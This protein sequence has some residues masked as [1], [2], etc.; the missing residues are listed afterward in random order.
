MSRNARRRLL[1]GLAIALPAAWTRPIVESVIL[2]AHAQTSAPGCS[3]PAGCYVTPE[4]FGFQSFQWPGGARPFAVD[5][6]STV[7]CEGEAESFTMVVGPGPAEAAELITCGDS[8]TL[9]QVSTTPSIVPD[10]GFFTCIV[11]N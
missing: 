1:Q 10:C 11:G 9:V 5:T 2:P 3:A 8:E 4:P 6:F 7:T